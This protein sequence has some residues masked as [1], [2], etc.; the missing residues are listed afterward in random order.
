MDEIEKAVNIFKAS[1][2]PFELM[3]CNSTYPMKNNA[4]HLRVMETLKTYFNCDVGYSGYETGRIV[5]LAAVILGAMRR[6]YESGHVWFRSVSI[7]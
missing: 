4:A 1:N 7:H 5:S 6:Y 3:H 2:C